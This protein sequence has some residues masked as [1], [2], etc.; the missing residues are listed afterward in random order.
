MIRR[1]EGS[2]SKR[3]TVAEL[4]KWTEE[5]FQRLRFETPRLDAEVL[6]AH[7]LANTRLE[8][9]TGY[10]K[11]VEPEE[12][13]R[14]RGLVERR[15]HREPV[16]YITGSREF[17]SLSFEVTPA[18]L[19]PRP[20]TEHLVEA[21]LEEHSKAC[22]NAAPE[23][24]RR[25]LDLCTGS[26]NVAIAL[27]VNA[28]T[29]FVDAVDSSAQ[30]LEVARR[31]AGAQGVSDRVAFFQGDLF[32]PLPEAG[33]QYRVIVSNPPYI[34]KSDFEKLMDDVRLHEPREA[35]FDSKSPDGDG[36]GFYRA[37]AREASRRLEEDGLLA[38]EVGVGQAAAVLE[39]LSMSGWKLEKI[40][41]DF[42][43][44]ERIVA[45]RVAR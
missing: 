22:S 8:L 9:Y 45:V 20:E 36:L 23:A 19:I 16:A 37:I 35:L 18:V 34:A 11:L 10:H 3:W 29:A 21:A 43:G 5:Y 31:N 26:G 7:A 12:R 33:R 6:L 39:I 2:S 4:L 1:E 32:F 15:A 40:I 14:F 44:I 27:A 24:P 13:G 25:I 42:G 28:P 17:Y 38:L 30:A 41:K